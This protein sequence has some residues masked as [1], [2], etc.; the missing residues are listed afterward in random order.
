MVKK[1]NIK[2]IEPEEIE[3]IEEFDDEEFDFVEEVEE[4]DEKV[5]K[6]KKSSKKEIELEEDED[7]EL[8]P[9]TVEE[10][11]I[12]IEKKLNLVL[13][14]TI[15]AAL[16]SLLTFISNLADGGS[17]TTT[18]TESETEATESSYDTSAFTK[19]T[20]QELEATSKGKS[21]IVWIGR[22]G[23]GFCSQYVPTI[24]EIGKKFDETIYYLDLASIFDFSTQQVGLLDEEAYEIMMGFETDK[25]NESIMENFGATP[26]TLIIKNNKIVGSFTGALDE[27]TITSTLEEEGF[28]QAK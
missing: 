25:D 19:I 15:I 26:M 7:E 11:V 5:V 17:S 23:C 22:Q 10:R 12:S 18:P 4:K 24:T 6:N 27:A 3:E 28:K 1:K 2:E 21:I 14:I 8:E 20:A 16:F 9:L 13:I